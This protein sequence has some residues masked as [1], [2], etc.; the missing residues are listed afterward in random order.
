MITDVVQKKG[1]KELPVK[2]VYESK[3][4]KIK[5]PVIPKAIEALSEF[6]DLREEKQL[7]ANL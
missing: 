3:A 4:I 5:P 7:I 2:V 6:K 1:F